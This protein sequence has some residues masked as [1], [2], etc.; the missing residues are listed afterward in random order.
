[1]SISISAGT[2]PSSSHQSSSSVPCAQIL[3][4]R[5]SADGRHG[6]PCTPSIALPSNLCPSGS[7]ATALALIAPNAV[8]SSARLTPQMDPINTPCLHLASDLLMLTSFGILYMICSPNLGL[9]AEVD[10]LLVL[11]VAMRP[12]SSDML[13]DTCVWAAHSISH[14]HIVCDGLILAL[15]FMS[16]YT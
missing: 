12:S 13:Q 4:P 14:G 6:V 2:S 7:A 11:W 1:M 3:I 9:A 15:M 5:C 16:R 8:H 10:L